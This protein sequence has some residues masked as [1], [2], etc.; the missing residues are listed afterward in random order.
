MIA[1]NAQTFGLPQSL[2]IP[3]AAAS[4]A[5]IERYVGRVKEQ[6]DARNGWPSALCVIPHHY[7]VQT[8]PNVGLWAQASAPVY[9]ARL[10][11]QKQ[12][13]V[14]VDYS[15]YKGAYA[16][17]GMPPVPAGYFLDHIQNREAIRLRG[18]SH[19]YLRLCPVSRQVNTSGGHA[20]GGEGMEKDFLR[21]LKNESPALQDKVAQALAVPIV[22]ADP[23][24]LTKMLNIPPGTSILPGVRDTQG[25]FY[26]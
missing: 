4:I 19:P 5:A 12:V 20:A 16:R 15:A 8:E 14:H 25:L 18:Y 10:H 13:W 23:M 26:P 6:I 11:P 3:I 24:D 2:I 9:Q 7:P 21:G 22:Y 1:P 17:F